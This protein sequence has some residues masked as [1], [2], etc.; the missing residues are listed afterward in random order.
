MRKWMIVLVCFATL[1]LVAV[2]QETGVEGVWTAVEAVSDGKKIPAQALDTVKLTLT[3]KA[4]KYDVVIQ[5]KKIES[6]TYKIDASKKPAHIDLTIVEGDE[7]GKVQQ[8]LFKI[9]Q[10]KLTLVVNDGKGA[11]RPKA[12]ESAEGS[13]LELTVLARKK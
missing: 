10:D 11:E 1:S 12:F 2:A 3:M 5:G 4:G 9:E 13:K 8:G 6:G 7:K